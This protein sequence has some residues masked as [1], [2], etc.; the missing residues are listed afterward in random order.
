VPLFDDLLAK[1]FFPE[2]LPPCFSTVSLAILATLPIGTLPTQFNNPPDSMP[3]HY[4]FARGGTGAIRRL[5][6]IVNPVAFYALAQAI[7]TNWTL[8]DTHLQGTT[9]SQSRPMYWPGA[10]RAFKKLS[11]TNRFLVGPKAR[12]RSSARA[13]LLADISQ[14]YH[15]IYTHSIA[16][17]FHT[18]PVAKANHGHALYGN[19]IDS[20]V[21]RGQ[22]RQTRGIPIGPDTSLVI[23]ESV[24]AEVERNILQRIPNLRGTRFV[25]DYELCFSDLG[26]AEHA[27]SVLQEELQKF[28][29]QLN[30]TKTKIASPPIRFEPDWVGDFRT[31]LLRTNSGQYGDLVRFFDLITRHLEP[32]AE[33]HVAK[34]AASKLLRQGF[35]PLQTNHAV[36]QALLC[37]LLVAQPSAAKEIVGCLLVLKAG[38]VPID[39]GLI[40]GSFAELIRKAAP[41]GHHFEISWVL[42]G[43]LRLGLNIDLGTAAIL[44]TCDNAVVALMS[45]NAWQLGLAPA[46]NTAMW[47][48]HMVTNELHDE[49][50]LLSYE[51]RRLGWLPSVGVPDHI[52]V[53]P[54]FCFLRAQAVNFY[55]PI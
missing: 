44:S 6:S 34:Y 42:Y 30:P 3:C 51:A 16:W 9:L 28:E 20:L 37:Q 39:E 7:A 29:L 14:F 22:D 24:L 36:Y 47:A 55:Q 31:F 8:I 26:A 54:A 45:L 17:A 21:Q 2:E 43:I 11:Y 49:N 15:S 48:T 27:M 12:S 5:L 52:Q 40:M 33:A 25:D 10:S 1:G 19:R 53:D 35:V 32:D 41:L 18:K 50:W 46:I 4:S 38:G 23:A 13:Y